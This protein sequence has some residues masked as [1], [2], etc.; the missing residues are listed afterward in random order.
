[1]LIR[2]TIPAPA[3]IDAASS[4]LPERPGD[5]SSPT[6]CV[7]SPVGMSTVALMDAAQTRTHDM[8]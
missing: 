3:D 6:S 5:V 8:L 4:R 7:P 2:N 1:V